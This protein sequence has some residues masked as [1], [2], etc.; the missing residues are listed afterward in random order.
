MGRPGPPG[1]R[2]THSPGLN[3]LDHETFTLTRPAFSVKTWIIFLAVIQL[4]NFPNFEARARFN[5]NTT[6]FL[7]VLIRS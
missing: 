2:G 4:D 3:A 6:E 7:T 5:Q 1:Q